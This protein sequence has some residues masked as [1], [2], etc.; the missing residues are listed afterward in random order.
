MFSRVV[1]N[2]KADGAVLTGTVQAGRWPGDAPIS[3]GVIEGNRFAFNAIGSTPS[4]SGYP[5]M[6]F[7]GTFDGNQMKLTM[8]WSCVG[9]DDAAAPRSDLEATR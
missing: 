4:S 2:L 3:D 8:A 7:S 5:K 6:V 1:L 9:C